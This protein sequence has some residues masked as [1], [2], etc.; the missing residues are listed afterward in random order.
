MS[1]IANF[2]KYF[3]KSGKHMLK[4]FGNLLGHMIKTWI[5]IGAYSIGALI[6]L[7]NFHL[8]ILGILF[9]IPI[10]RKLIILFIIIRSITA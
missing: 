3:Q 5:F 6:C 4:N 2:I 7:K 10:F 1:K 8:L 9:R